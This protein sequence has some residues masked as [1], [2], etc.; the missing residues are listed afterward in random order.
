MLKPRQV[1]GV[2]MMNKLA[3]NVKIGKFVF[4]ARNIFP[5][6]APQVTNGQPGKIPMIQARDKRTAKLCHLAIR[7]RSLYFIYEPL[8]SSLIQAML[9]TSKPSAPSPMATFV[10]SHP[11]LKLASAPEVH[12]VV[13]PWLILTITKASGVSMMNNPTVNHVLISKL[14]FVARDQFVIHLPTIPTSLMGKLEISK[15]WKVS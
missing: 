14:D 15:S 4:V 10:L 8:R 6:N 13:R 2:S 11:L 9:E 5:M 7:L 3:F 1:S 12:L